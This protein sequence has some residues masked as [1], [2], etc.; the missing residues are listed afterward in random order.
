MGD[1]FAGVSYFFVRP[2]AQVKTME[3]SAPNVISVWVTFPKFAT[4]IWGKEAF[5]IIGSKVGKPIKIKYATAKREGC[6]A[7]LPI[8]TDARLDFP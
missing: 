6:N 3:S 2:W 7:K 5:C 8:S 4:E 1:H